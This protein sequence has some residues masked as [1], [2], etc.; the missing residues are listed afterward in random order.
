MRTAYLCPQISVRPE[1]EAK[2]SGFPGLRRRPQVAWHGTGE[3]EEMT[4]IIFYEGSG[5]C[6]RVHPVE[7]VTGC[8]VMECLTGEHPNLGS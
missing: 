2:L 6:V 3:F 1:A 8:Q 7:S 4:D 5:L